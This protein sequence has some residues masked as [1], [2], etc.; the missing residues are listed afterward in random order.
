MQLFL[1]RWF[2]LAVLLLLA[3]C[4]ATPD[5]APPRALPAPPPGFRWERVP[6]IKAAFP[7]PDGWFFT[8]RHLEDSYACAISRENVAKSGTLSTGFTVQ[9][10]TGVLAKTGKSAAAYAA[11]RL[12]AIGAQ[13]ENTIR[14]RR[15]MERG[16]LKGEA[17]EYRSAPVVAA[18]S[19]GHL[20]V[21]TNEQTDTLYVLVFEAPETAWEQE[22]QVHG[23][24]I[25][26]QMLLDE[27]F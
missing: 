7:C 23:D 1:R 20:A 8:G 21:I 15:D 14:F 25:M 19:I 13:P 16:L 26:H 24:V 12:E 2:S 11:A 27:G 3:G 18:P 4:R 17:V 6:A 10:I 9:V 22:W 5:G